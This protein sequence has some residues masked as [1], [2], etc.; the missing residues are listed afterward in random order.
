MLVEGLMGREPRESSEVVTQ[1]T[2]SLAR[3]EGRESSGCPSGC[4]SKEELGTVL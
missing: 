2:P 3:H 4:L 1:V